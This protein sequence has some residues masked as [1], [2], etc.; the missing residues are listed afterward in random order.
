MFINDSLNNV[1]NKK[2]KKKK[3]TVKRDL[4]ATTENRCQANRYTHVCKHC[5]SSIEIRAI[6]KKM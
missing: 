5:S 1:L 3:K 4:I 6:N 2:T